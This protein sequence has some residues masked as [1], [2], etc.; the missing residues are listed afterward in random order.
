MIISLGAKL[1]GLGIIVVIAFS[2]VLCVLSHWNRCTLRASCNAVLGVWA[3]GMHNGM[4]QY[5]D[6]MRYTEVGSRAT[7]RTNRHYRHRKALNAESTRHS[8]HRRHPVF[9]TTR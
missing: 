4:Q 7:G 9:A 1:F 5:Y 2:L 6:G 8:R 3:H